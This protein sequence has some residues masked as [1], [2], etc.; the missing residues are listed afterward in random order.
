MT[1]V[2]LPCFMLTLEARKKTLKPNS[3]AKNRS[4]LA[5][6]LALTF[7]YRS[8]S[9]SPLDLVINRAP[10]TVQFRSQFL[11]FFFSRTIETEIV[12]RCAFFIENRKSRW[13]NDVIVSEKGSHSP[14]EKKVSIIRLLFLYFFENTETEQVYM[15]CLNQRILNSTF[16]KL[17]Y[18]KNDKLWHIPT[19]HQNCN[20]L[21]SATRMQNIGRTLVSDSWS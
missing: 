3:N 9:I 12:C 13:I 16:R 7:S 14:E 1:T 21:W 17:K 10:F 5:T 20:Y 11:F 2:L 18:L 6:T 15:I 4:I 8:D 19:L